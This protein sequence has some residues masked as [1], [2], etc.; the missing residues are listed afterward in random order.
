MHNKFIKWGFYQST[1]DQRIYLHRHD[2]III[3]LILAVDEMPCCSNNKDIFYWYDNFLKQTFN[4]KIL[5]RF[6]SFIG[7][8][9][10]KTADRVHL[11]HSKYLNGCLEMKI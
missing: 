7:W 4:V 9:I 3:N 6:C 1:Q 2:L 10:T 8:E 5:E 11:I